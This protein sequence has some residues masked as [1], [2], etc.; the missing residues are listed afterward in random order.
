[1]CGS[2]PNFFPNSVMHILIYLILFIISFP[3]LLYCSVRIVNNPPDRGCLSSKCAGDTF[4]RLLNL[5]AFNSSCL[6]GEVDTYLEEL[7]PVHGERP[8]IGIVLYLPEGFVSSLVQFAFDDVDIVGGLDNGIHTLVP[9][10][11]ILSNDCIPIGY[12]ISCSF[13]YYFKRLAIV[14]MTAA[15]LAALDPTLSVSARLILLCIFVGTMI[16]QPGRTL[17]L[18]PTLAS[19][20]FM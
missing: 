12:F 4:I 17:A 8:G 13:L 6:R 15:M 2:I 3:P 19:I 10:C 5:V 11:R 18:C 16:S 14:A 9:S 7:P 20:P 1:M